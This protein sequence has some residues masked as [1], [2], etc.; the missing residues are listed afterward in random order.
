MSSLSLVLYYCQTL[1]FIPV[2]HLVNGVMFPPVRPH[3]VVAVYPIAL[4]DVT[5]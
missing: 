1:V 3:D 5:H 2:V 4:S